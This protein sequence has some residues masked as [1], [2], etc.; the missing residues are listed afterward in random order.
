MYP[1][2]LVRMNVMAAVTLYVIAV[3]G[4]VGTGCACFAAI[5]AAIFSRSCFSAS[6]IARSALVTRGL[7]TVVPPR[8]P[9]PPPRPRPLP[10]VS[11]RTVPPRP[12][13]RPRFTVPSALQCVSKRQQ[14]GKSATY[15]STA[16][17]S[18]SGISGPLY[19]KK[20]SFAMSACCSHASSVSSMKSSSLS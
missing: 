15:L 12:R 1:V 19:T 3:G 8:E 10:D 4:K 9:G 11:P 18:F 6:I 14:S 20:P 16:G 2:S 7:R 17:F 13:P 5:V